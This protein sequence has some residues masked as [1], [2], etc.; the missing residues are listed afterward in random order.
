VSKT[1]VMLETVTGF[2]RLYEGPASMS[3]CVHARKEESESSF[4]RK[5][6]H[7]GL[8]PRGIKGLD[9]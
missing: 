6:V 1:E 9:W 3:G 4:V 2:E 5:L 8:I 7:A